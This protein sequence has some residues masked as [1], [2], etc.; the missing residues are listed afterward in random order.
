MNFDPYFPFHGHN[1]P[2]V[3]AGLFGVLFLVL[4]FKAPKLVAKLVLLVAALALF[5]GA[6]WWV[7]HIRS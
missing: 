6:Y 2:A 4:V 3:V 7:I 5:A 1:L